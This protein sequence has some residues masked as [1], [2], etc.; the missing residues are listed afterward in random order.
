MGRG[1][2]GEIRGVGV[3]AREARS[4]IDFVFSIFVLLKLCLC[5]RP[6]MVQAHK[7]PTQ[8]GYAGEYTRSSVRIMLAENSLRRRNTR[9][10][11][12]STCL[13]RPCLEHLSPRRGRSI[14]PAVETRLKPQSST[15]TTLLSN[16]PGQQQ[17]LQRVS[18]PLTAHSAEHPALH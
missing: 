12:S 1:D 3:C 10:V 18:S 7:P 2:D 11:S 9:N 6:A 13:C 14:Y 17:H 16:I 4:H 8:C 5:P 15:S